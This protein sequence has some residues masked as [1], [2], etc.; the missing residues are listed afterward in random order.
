MC[1]ERHNIE[2]VYISSLVQHY[3]WIQC[4][5]LREKSLHTYKMMDNQFLCTHNIVYYLKPSNWR[6]FSIQSGGGGEQTFLLWQK[7]EIFVSQVKMKG[8]SVIFF[9][10]A[11]FVLYSAHWVCFADCYWCDILCLHQY[12]DYPANRNALILTR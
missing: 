11:L 4:H 9:F 3:Y 5:F 1:C 8:F 2:W 10:L 7:R 6:Y 12:N